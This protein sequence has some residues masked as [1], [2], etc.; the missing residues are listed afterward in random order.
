MAYALTRIVESFLYADLITGATPDIEN[1]SIIL[2]LML[3]K[4]T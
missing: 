3:R 2:K 4:D 1:A